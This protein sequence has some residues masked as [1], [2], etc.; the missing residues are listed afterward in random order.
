[1]QLR[2]WPASAALPCHLP[3]G[4]AGLILTS[5]SQAVYAAGPLF[6]PAAARVLAGPHKAGRAS[7][8]LAWEP[9]QMLSAPSAVR[10]T[11]PF[12]A[13]ADATIANVARN[14]AVSSTASEA[15]GR[16]RRLG[17]GGQEVAAGW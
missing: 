8:F 6:H 2:R 12:L 4:P 13:S 7:V 15:A 11:A 14:G 16:P 9:A 5:A 10:L 17:S 1:M 3:G